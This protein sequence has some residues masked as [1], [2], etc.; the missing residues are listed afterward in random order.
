MPVSRAL[1]RGSG[2]PSKVEARIAKVIIAGVGRT[3]AAYATTKEVMQ[4]GPY[5]AVVSAGVAGCPDHADSSR[6]LVSAAD[7]ALYTAKSAGKNRV[8][9]APGAGR[10]E[11]D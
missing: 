2:S 11:G 5:A 6:G 4:N 8:V 3:N 7:A 9:V 1:T 10:R